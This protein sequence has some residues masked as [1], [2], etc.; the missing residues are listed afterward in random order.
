M[1]AVG[2]QQVDVL[3]RNVDSS[4][5]RLFLEVVALLNLRL[6]VLKALQPS[7]CLCQHRQDLRIGVGLLRNRHGE[8]LY[9]FRHILDFPVVSTDVAVVFRQRI[10]LLYQILHLFL[11]IGE[12]LLMGTGLLFQVAFL[13]LGFTDEIRQTLL[14]AFRRHGGMHV[15][16]LVGMDA[17]AAAACGGSGG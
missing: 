15:D 1:L 2:R 9:L 11:Q 16:G 13:F 6:L 17:H 5:R 7:V 8:R 12:R 10:S 3:T 4:S 14:T